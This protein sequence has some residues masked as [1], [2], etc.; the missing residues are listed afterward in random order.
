MKKAR[1]TTSTAPVVRPLEL[2]QLRRATGGNHVDNPGQ[3]PMNQ[4]EDPQQRG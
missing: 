2:E 1:K 4:I 3:T